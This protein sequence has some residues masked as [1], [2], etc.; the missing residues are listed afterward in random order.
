MKTSYDLVCIGFG[1]V[2]RELLRYSP[3]LEVLIV[4]DNCSETF[5][6]ATVLRY[7]DFSKMINQ[8]SFSK[9]IVSVR[10]EFLTVESRE[11]IVK[12]LGFWDYLRACNVIVL[13]SVSVYGVGQDIHYE[14][15]SLSPI[16]T[17]AVSKVF[18]ENLFLSKVSSE[19]I[20]ILRVAN[21]YGIIGISLFFDRL[22]ISATTGKSLSIP[23]CDCLRDFVSI[24]DLFEF[25]NFWLNPNFSSNLEVLNFGTGHS[26]NLTKIA[27]LAMSLGGFEFEVIREEARPPIAISRISVERLN[28]LW[29]HSMVQLDAVVLRQLLFT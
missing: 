24:L 22:R 10:L 15:D 21:L 17:Y 11:F 27:Q 12:N 28:Q 3:N 29:N 5:P 2:I 6:R 25:I 18:L 14:E 4:S 19:N 20:L 7:Y 16:D 23:N 8:I 1:P 9:V 26:S 13:S